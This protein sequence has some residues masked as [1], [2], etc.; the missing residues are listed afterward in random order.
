MAT[1]RS[2]QSERT[3][4]TNVVAIIKGRK[5]MLV[6]NLDDVVGLSKSGKNTIVA[7]THGNTTVAGVK[8]GLNAYK[9]ADGE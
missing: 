9:S 7:T 1:G 2:T 6:I 3:I 4:G 5:L 8:L